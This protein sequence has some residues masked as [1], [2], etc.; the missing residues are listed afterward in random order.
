MT[1]TISVF[2]FVIVLIILILLVLSIFVVYHEREKMMAIFQKFDIKKYLPT[3][4]DNSRT[5]K[6][7]TQNTLTTA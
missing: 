2:T 1:D 3:L 5:S 6:E 4:V 7:V